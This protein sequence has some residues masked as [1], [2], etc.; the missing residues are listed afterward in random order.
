MAHPQPTTEAS[1]LTK[2]GDLQNLESVETG[3]HPRLEESYLVLIKIPAIIER[4]DDLM[5]TEATSR[6]HAGIRR[7]DYN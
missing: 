2:T 3:K 7:V 4:E 1:R 6:A 5:R